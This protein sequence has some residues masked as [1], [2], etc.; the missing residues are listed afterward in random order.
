MRIYGSLFLEPDEDIKVDLVR[1][2]PSIVIGTVH[3]H[4]TWDQLEA[5]SDKA[6]N[7]LREKPA[8][9]EPEAANKSAVAP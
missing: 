1:G 9:A 2:H 8:P 5:L 3:I 6:W 7:L 4:L